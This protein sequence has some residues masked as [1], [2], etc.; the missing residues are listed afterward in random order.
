MMKS[1]NRFF[2]VLIALVA[3]FTMSLSVFAMPESNDTVTAVVE[4]QNSELA[5]YEAQR[6]EK[7][8][9]LEEKISQLE[10]QLEESEQQHKEPEVKQAKLNLRLDLNALMASFPIMGVG[11][12]GIFIV[13][14]AIALSV[15]LL[16]KFFPNK[17]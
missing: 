13:I 6:E 16:T 3:V 10:A 8:S 12:A 17:Q 9:K 5:S 15:T 14:A 2:S 1:I 11:M 7:L 4:N